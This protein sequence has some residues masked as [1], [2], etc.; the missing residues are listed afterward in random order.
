MLV[1]PE[2]QADAVRHLHGFLRGSVAIPGGVDL[3][4]P[5]LEE[6]LDA[7]QGELHR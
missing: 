6:S 2:S 3:T 5:I 1:P 4:A 7:G